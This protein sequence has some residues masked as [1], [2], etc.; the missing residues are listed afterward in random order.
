MPDE[1]DSV[2][3]SAG[4][5]ICPNNS[6]NVDNVSLSIA[7]SL[8]GLA[9]SNS[10]W[11]RLPRRCWISTESIV[12]QPSAPTSKPFWNALTRSRAVPWDGDSSDRLS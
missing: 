8:C 4:A 2:G 6:S 5:K 9:G 7:M 1:G 11:G 12:A 3:A 10:D